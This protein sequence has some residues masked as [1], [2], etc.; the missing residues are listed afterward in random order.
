MVEYD[1]TML[2]DPRLF[3][4]IAA[5]GMVDFSVPPSLLAIYVL[6]AVPLGSIPTT[7]SFCGLS[8]LHFGRDMGMLGERRGMLLSFVMH[9]LVG[10]VYLR[11]KDVA[12]SLMMLYSLVWHIPGESLTLTLAT[13][14]APGRARTPRACVA[15][16]YANLWTV[17]NYRA[18]ALALG[19]SVAG[20]AAAGTEAVRS[21]VPFFRTGQ[22]R[23]S[24]VMQRI[25]ICHIIV[26]ELG[27][28]QMT[29]PSAIAAVQAAVRSGA[30]RVMAEFDG[31]RSALL[32]WRRRT[33]LE[34]SSD[35]P[36]PPAAPPF[37]RSHYVAH[38]PRLAMSC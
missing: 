14:H 12:F 4:L 6:A 5:H 38:P 24:H 37:S 3:G 27:N 21:A 2:S 23:F 33:R 26:H 9:S 30:T 19:T 10:L 8:L 15:A 31:T 22:L 32:H 17:K 7:G 29:L 20:V 18:L 13:P 36:A 16:L 25:V 35:P 34:L 28:R 11:D 1:L